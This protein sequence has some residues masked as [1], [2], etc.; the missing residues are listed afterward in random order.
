MKK[1]WLIAHRGYRPQGTENTLAAFKATG[2]SDVSWVEL[3]VHTTKDGVV[4][5]HHDF[6]INGLDINM[7]SYQELKKADPK[8]TTFDQ[9]IKALGQTPLIIEIKPTCT[10]KHIINQIK[11]NKH[12]L[13]ASFK[14]EV[15]KELL[16][17]GC[18][19]KHILLLQHKHPFGQI[20]KALKLGL[21][22]VGVNQRLINPYLYF[23]AQNKGLVVYTYTVNSALQAK[24]FRTL[25]PKMLICSDR[26]NELAKIK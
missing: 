1:D 25:Y 21:G 7:H 17:L 19:K 6:D 9:A 14:I 18:D 20:Q 15:I 22:G 11:N 5:C 13:V 26:P 8:L 2:G 10:A 23:R 16:D 12:W 4:I 24:L 3:D